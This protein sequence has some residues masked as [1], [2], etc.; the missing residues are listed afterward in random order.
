[1]SRLY[2]VIGNQYFKYELANPVGLNKNYLPGFAY[3]FKKFSAVYTNPEA[4]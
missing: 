1:M 2:C 4:K 3:F